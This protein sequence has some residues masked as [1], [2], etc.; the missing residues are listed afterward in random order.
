ACSQ[1]TAINTGQLGSVYKSCGTSFEHLGKTAEARTS[2]EEA[3]SLLSSADEIAYVRERIHALG[4]GEATAADQS[5]ASAQ[6]A[7]GVIAYENGDA[8]GAQTAFQAALHLEGP[9]SEKG[10]AH[11]Y[12]GAMAYQARHYAEARNHV[13]NAVAHAPSP[14]QG[15][16]SSMLNW[17]WDEHPAAAGTSAA[18]GT[19]GAAAPG[20]PYSPTE[21]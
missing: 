17:R 12:L 19:P 4:G 2:Y 13:E 20:A 5:P 15:W 11:Y 14:E 1:S 3:L 9:E 6:V 7:A 10:R 16:A 18:A 21:I 8:T